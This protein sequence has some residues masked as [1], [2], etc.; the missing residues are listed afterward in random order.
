LSRSAI[1]ALIFRPGFSTASKVTNISGRGVGLDVV[2]SNVESLGGTIELQSETGRSTTFRVK[3]PLTLAIVSVLLVRAGTHRIAIPQA[4]VVE[5][6]RLEGD[7]GD[8]GIE[9]LGGVPVYRLRGKLLP[10]VFLNHELDIDNNQ[11]P[12]VGANIVVLQGDDRQFGL[13]VAGVEDS[14]EIV[15]KPLGGLHSGLP[16]AGATILGDG[17]IALIL[18]IFRLGLA[19]GVVSETRAQTVAAQVSSAVEGRKKTERLVF[20]HGEDDERLALDFDQVN[21]L[22]Y[23]PRSSIEQVGN[24]LLV[25]YGDEILQLIDLQQTL[26]ERRKKARN[27]SARL[28]EDTVPVVVCTVNGRGIGLMAHRIVDIVDEFLKA[29]RPGSR[30]GVRNCAVIRERV[31]EILDLEALIRLSDPEFFE[32]T[33]DQE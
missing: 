16:F 9:D 33:I 14:Q 22:E 23:F 10:L 21:R 1:E 15:V 18:D 30:D 24:Q 26:P 2:R 20:L 27:P 13:V 29:R 8:S 25:Q 19:A 28:Q 32:R 5:L 17:Q 11:D 12:G 4:S 7:G 6:I 31:T 3:I